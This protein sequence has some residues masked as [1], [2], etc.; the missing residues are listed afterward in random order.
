MWVFV[1]LKCRQNVE[2]LVLE[3]IL[4]E[5]S[6]AQAIVVQSYFMEITNLISIWLQLSHNASSKLSCELHMQMLFNVY[7]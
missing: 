5:M 1:P 2:I 6:S 3:W 4:N 7:Y